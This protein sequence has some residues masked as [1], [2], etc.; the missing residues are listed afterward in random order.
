MIK[1]DVFVIVHRS[2]SA[3]WMDLASLSSEPRASRW[4]P[5][6]L[7]M[8]IRI[9]ILPV[10]TAESHHCLGRNCRYVDAWQCLQEFILK[11]I[12]SFQRSV[13]LK[14]RNTKGD[15]EALIKDALMPTID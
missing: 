2:I 5:G 15:S 12:C 3:W 1:A 4:S 11:S 8:S 14:Q 13:T 10:K 7:Y 6:V 9:R